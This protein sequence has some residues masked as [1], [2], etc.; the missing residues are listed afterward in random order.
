MPKLLVINPNTSG[1]VSTLL[2]TH[3]QQW[4]GSTVQV[5]TVTAPFGAPYIACE[6]SYAVAGH[7]VMDAYDKAL[8]PGSP[9]VDGVLIGCFGDPGLWALRESCSAKVTGLAEASFVQA[10]RRG[11]FAIV[12]GGARWPAIL[13]RLAQNLGFADHLAGIQTVEKSGI[14]LAGDPEA[15]HSLLAQACNTAY[16]QWGVDVIIVG[17]AGLAGMAQTIAPQVP[18]PLI[19]SLQAGVSYLLEQI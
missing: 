15:A 10:A 18:I 16:Q 1:S 12:T 4:A 9:A 3:A 19:D 11:R 13:Q 2:Q 5:Q 17:G 7:A 8:T 6:S 14:E